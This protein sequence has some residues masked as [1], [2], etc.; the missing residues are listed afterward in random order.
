MAIPIIDNVLS[1][2]NKFIPDSD[3]QA[4]LKATIEKSINDG[5]IK[6][7]EIEKETYGIETNRIVAGLERLPIP[8]MIWAFVIIALNNAVLIP[9]VAFFAHTTLPVITLDPLFVD[10]VKVVIAAIFTKKTVQRFS[11]NPKD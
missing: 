9:Y 6:F 1:I 5:E 2:V 8:V 4:E 10:T 7:A 11:K 3:K